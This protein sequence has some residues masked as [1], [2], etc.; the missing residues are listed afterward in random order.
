M[1]NRLFLG[2]K[3]FFYIENLYNETM[4]NRVK[5][6][7]HLLE[8]K[9]ILCECINRSFLNDEVA[10]LDFAWP[11]FAPKGGQFFLIRPEL[12]SVFLARPF[13]AAGRQQATGQ[14]FVRFLV[15]IRGLG[16]KELVELRV[17]QKA[18]LTGPL[19]RGW[20]SEEIAQGELALVSG[21]VGVA[22]LSFFAKELEAEGRVFDFYAGFRSSAFGLEGI[23]PR[24]LIISSED[25]SSGIKGRI[26][27]HFSPAQYGAVYTCGP[28]A[29]LKTIARQCKAAGVP[30]FISLERRMA[31][32]TGACLGCSVKTAQGYKRCCSDGPVFNGGDVIFDE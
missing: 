26:P 19:G 15:A 12:T 18:F 31:C 4:S 23:K 7:I 20:A 9:Y 17:G 30:C 32:G 11:G 16:T 21:G 27:E 13:S 1:K 2:S 10:S 22:P 14:Q 29:M 25:G 5:D 24:K 6:E 28:E 3:D 8:K